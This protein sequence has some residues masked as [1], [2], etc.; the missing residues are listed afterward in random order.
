MPP[1]FIRSFALAF[2]LFASPAAQAWNAA[3]HRLSAIIAWQGMSPASRSFVSQALREHPDHVRWLEKSGDGDAMLV[4]AEATTWPDSI[5]RDTRFDG[6]T[7]TLPGFPDM[8]RHSDWHYADFDRRGKRGRGQ[9]DRQIAEL[10][11]ILRST[12]EISEIAWAIPWLAHLVADIHQPLHAGYSEDRGGN[13]VLVE[14][15]FAARQP[16]VK[17]HTYWDD[18]PGPS[19]LRGKRLR[20]RAEALL[21]GQARPVQ[22]DVA[23]WLQES[24]QLLP[25][26]YPAARGSVTLLIDEAWRDQARATADRRIAEAGHRLGKLL[27]EIQRHRVSRETQP[28]PASISPAR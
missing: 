6:A 15:P 28:A 11:K 10:A 9:I 25:A 4:F 26:A 7:A 3:G 14:N 19:G 2:I 21:A 13:E 27:E 5:R 20:L 24:R 23:R 16:F 18:L 12:A 17:L 22:G 1:L 8:D